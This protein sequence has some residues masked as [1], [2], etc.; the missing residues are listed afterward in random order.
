[1][2]GAALVCLFG[3]QAYAIAMMFW[4]KHQTGSAVI[5]DLL[6]QNIPLVLIGGGVLSVISC[7]ILVF[8]RPFR[9]YM[10]YEPGGDEKAVENR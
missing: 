6:N 10:A 8:S 5:A 1:M 4:I 7:V 3:T 9:E 2:A